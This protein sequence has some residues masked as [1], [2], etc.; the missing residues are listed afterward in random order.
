[1]THLYKLGVASA[2]LLA[3]MAC[4]SD[5]TENAAADADKKVIEVEEAEA[6]KTSRP[7][8]LI[9]VADDL[10][11]G[12]IGVNGSGLIR[13]PNIDQ[14]ASEGVRF[15][16]GYVTAA[17]CAPS[18][19]ALMT[20]QHQQRFGFEFNP[21]GRADVGIPVDVETIASKLD[22]EGY[23]TGL[24]GKW[25]LGETIELHP[26]SRGFD[27]FYGFVEGGNG[28]LTSPEEGEWMQDP[29]PGSAKGFKPIHLQDGFDE[30]EDIEGDL[31]S[32]LNDAAVD[33]IDNSGDEPFFLV[34]THFAPHSP[35]QATTEQLEPYANV[36]NKAKRIYAAMV[37]AMDGSVGEIIDAV[38]R[39]GVRDNTLIIFMSD[40]G[41]AHYIG[42]GTCSNG[43]FAGYKGTYF[44]GGIRVPMIASWPGK[45]PEGTDYEKPIV[46]YDWS[47]TAL[48]LAGLEPEKEGV[49]G[50]DLMPFLSG[51]GES[52][53]HQRIHW[54]TQPNITMRD[55]DWKMVLIERTDGK[56]MVELLFNIAEDPSEQNDLSAEHPDKL[57]EMKA[58]F[59]EWNATLPAP[60]YESQR[61]GS[62]PLPNGVEVNVYN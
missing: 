10:G 48:A 58:A 47:A 8:I 60:G 31:T 32:L 50:T 3:A 20:G 56:G 7:N 59:E 39:K 11:Y 44:E 52:G 14:L 5:K 26:L 33:F 25:H 17:V 19:A 13:T 28:Y 42:V 53:P 35:L 41:C 46:S 45:L 61:P 38:E 40:N 34:V 16:S 24:V 6:G 57:A 49:D 22:D 1:M 9:V 27:R 29:V 2:A 51:A 55:G 15:T 12:D 54:R 4:S 21:R 36:E 43:D 62:F 23:H 30:I 18:R 37:T